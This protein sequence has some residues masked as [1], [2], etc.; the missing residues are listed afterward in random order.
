VPA[1]AAA[2]LGWIIAIV[3]GVYF[4]GDRHAGGFDRTLTR[5]IHSL[6]GIRS[7]L[8]NVL[9]APTDSPAVYGLI[10]LLVAV[11]LIQRRWQLAALAVV[12]PAAAVGICELVLKPLFDRRYHDGGLS[13]PSG[14]MLAAGTVYAVALLA[15]LAVAPLVGRVLALVGGAA[16]AVVMA[17]GLVAMNYHY[18]TDAVGG[19]CLAI[20]I[21]LPCAVLADLVAG[22]TRAQS[23]PAP[24]NETDPSLLPE[25]RPSVIENS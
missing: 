12:A 3:L 24:R 14:H 11:G 22:R 5:E 1:L 16:L 20:G 4:A 19:F 13:Y 17:V 15:I 8:A 18:P 9:V 6:V 21:T 23:I 25:P 10:I 2:L 7:T